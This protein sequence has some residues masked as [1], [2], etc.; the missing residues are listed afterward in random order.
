MP[1]PKQATLYHN[2]RC[3]TSRKALEQLQ[4]AGYSVDII[5]Y[6]KNPPSRAVL[7]QLIHDAGLTVHDAVRSKEAIY[8][9]LNLA[10]P[11][12]TDEQLLDAMLAHPILINRPFVVTA[13]GSRLARPIEQ[14]QDIL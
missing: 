4:E 6:L 12:T 1:T 14:L 3:G 5:E 9:E 2:S 13:K 10:A 11:N 8:A 7:T